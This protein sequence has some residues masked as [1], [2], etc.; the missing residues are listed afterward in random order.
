MEQPSDS[1]GEGAAD[2]EQP[3]AF[4]QPPAAKKKRTPK[5]QGDGA[6]AKKQAKK[7]DALEIWHAGAEQRGRYRAD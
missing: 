7:D 5:G 4:G 1:E 6:W 3:P 2:E